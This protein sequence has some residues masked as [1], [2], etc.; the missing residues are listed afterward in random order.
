MEN[1][2]YPTGNILVGFTSNL[3]ALLPQLV[4]GLVLV[5]I[6]LIVGKMVKKIVVGLPEISFVKNLV[7]K[8]KFSQA[9]LSNVWYSLVGE[10]LKWSVVILFL[11]A[12]ADAWKLSQVG[13]ILSDFL[14]YIPNV[15]V[16]V[17]ISFIGLALAGIVRDLVKHGTSG[18]ESKSSNALSA[19]AEYSVITFTVLLVLNQLGIATELIKIIFTGFIVMISLAGGLAFGLGGQDAA[20]KIIDD[21]TKKVGK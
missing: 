4:T 6:G 19:L 2:L 17:V 12:A 8:T 5:L 11:I 16:A 15:L 13:S 20:K 21:F 3:L 1:I 10:I 14:A 7:G 18:L 9:I